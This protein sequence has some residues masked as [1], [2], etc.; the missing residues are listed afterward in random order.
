MTMSMGRRFLHRFFS[1]RRDWFLDLHVGFR[2]GWGFPNECHQLPRVLWRVLILPRGHASPS[3]AVLNDVEQR[4]VTT[5]LN[6]SGSQVG[7]LRVHVGAHLGVA[8]RV[9]AVA[10][11]AVIQVMLTRLT[12][13]FGL[14]A[15]WA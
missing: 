15:E 9:A 4:P 5:T 6:L 1:R 7:H 12:P 11:R 3:D 13:D 2:E 14:S 10:Q 8:L